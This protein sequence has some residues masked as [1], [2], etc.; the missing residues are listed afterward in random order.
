MEHE[1]TRKI[2]RRGRELQR[3]E[4]GLDVGVVGVGSVSRCASGGWWWKSSGVGIGTWIGVVRRG[5]RRE[6][7][8][9]SQHTAHEDENDTTHYISPVLSDVS[10]PV[11]SLLVEGREA[12]GGTW[13]LHITSTHSIYTILYTN[14]T[15]YHHTN[16][17]P[18]EVMITWYGNMVT[19]GL[20]YY[21]V[22]RVE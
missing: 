20:Y 6:S 8:G 19:A 7:D 11:G 18:G 15:G 21:V 9:S 22:V 1:R 4:V 5:Y 14:S 12:E 2:V 13:A 3:R 16:T 10:P 17:I